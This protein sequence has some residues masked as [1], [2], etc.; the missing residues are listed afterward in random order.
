MA[1][2]YI[3]IL[4]LLTVICNRDEVMSNLPHNG[5]SVCKAKS[6]TSHS[7]HM[8]VSASEIVFLVWKTKFVSSKECLLLDCSPSSINQVIIT[9]HFRVLLFL[10]FF[11]EI[12]QGGEIRKIIYMFLAIKYCYLGSLL[13]WHVCSFFSFFIQR[14]VFIILI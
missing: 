6:K 8:K 14:C 2:H 10:D 11:S 9:S 4:N 5:S 13:I 3:C 12:A 1:N 7:M